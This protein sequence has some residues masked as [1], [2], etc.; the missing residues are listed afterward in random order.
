MGT[1]Q[2]DATQWTISRSASSTAES[3]P[4]CL[5][6]TLSNSEGEAH[7][8][9]GS[10]PSWE[11]EQKQP[12]GWGDEGDFVITS[13]RFQFSSVQSCPI[14]CDPMNC[15]T[16]GIPSITNSQSPPKPMSI[17]SVMPSNHLILCRPLLLLPSI[18]PCIRVFSNESA[19]CIRWPKYWHFSFNISPS[20]EH[21]G[22]ISFRM[23]WL[24]LVQSKGLLR[25]TNTKFSPARGK[26]TLWPFSSQPVSLGWSGM[27]GACALSCVQLFVTLWTVAHQ[28]SL[29]VGFP[30][31]EYWT[32]LPFSP[33]WNFLNPGIKPESPAS[34]PLAGRSGCK[35]QSLQGHKG[36]CLLKSGQPWAGPPPRHHGLNTWWR[37]T[38]QE[39]AHSRAVERA[40]VT[41][42]GFLFDGR[43]DNGRVGNASCV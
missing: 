8:Y 32:G 30:R 29:S 21:P 19:L 31:Q 41:L 11:M 18:P 39:E 1:K 25:F 7:F 15:T 35:Y 6:N 10:S 37:I 34:P 43:R 9:F 36:R 16:S 26:S 28:A 22:L 23:D 4:P 24:D 42:R 40:D 3:P 14:L 5:F 17:V 33:P 12:G 38:R 20:N 27:V 2:T 13:S